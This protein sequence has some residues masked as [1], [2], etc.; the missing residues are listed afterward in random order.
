MS[1]YER[2]CRD[3]NESQ[4]DVDFNAMVAHY[5]KHGYVFSTPYFFVLA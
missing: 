1:P 4:K 2:S 3:F 5:L